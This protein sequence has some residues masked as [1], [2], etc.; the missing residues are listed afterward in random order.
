[1]A[2]IRAADGSASEWATQAAN[3][4]SRAIRRSRCGGIHPLF[5]VPGGA[6]FRLA[7]DHGGDADAIADQMAVMATNAAHYGFQVTGQ[8]IDARSWEM[9]LQSISDG[10][11]AQTFYRRFRQSVVE[12][13]LIVV[14]DE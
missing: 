14:G 9:R 5:V 12:S 2:R 6:E 4:A 3:A 1:M 7:V 8:V 11:D 13:G 10:D